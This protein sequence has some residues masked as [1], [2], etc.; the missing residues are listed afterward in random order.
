MGESA[1]ETTPRPETQGFVI[2]EVTR[3][4]R[5]GRLRP[6]AWKTALGV[7]NASYRANRARIRPLRASY[8]RNA[9]VLSVVTLLLMGYLFFHVPLSAALVALAAQVVYGAAVLRGTEYHLIMVRD[10]EGR[11]WERFGIANAVTVLRLVTL[12]A[13]FAYVVLARDHPSIGVATFSLCAVAALSDMADGMLA[14]QLNQ[15]S[16]FGRVYDPVVDILFNPTVSVALSVAGAFPWWLTALVFLRYGVAL[17]GGVMIWI[18]NTPFSMASTVIGKMTGF[19]LGWAGCFATIR[20]CFHTTW[21]TDGFL[22]G[23]FL[24][25]GALAGANAVH[26]F[27][28]GLRHI[29][30]RRQE[31][32]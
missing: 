32:K 9:A 17:V 22:L 23:F 30:R 2:A 24:A 8:F 7:A 19:V 18:W 21:T 29:Y 15:T 14:R 1:P 4:L 26:H 11:S 27:V 5:E 10:D 6:R 31:R 12:P 16:V 28:Q 25:A 3:L 13:V 20:L